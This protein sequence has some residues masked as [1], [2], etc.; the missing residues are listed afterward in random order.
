MQSQD[1]S[2]KL[3]EIKESLSKH[4]LSLKERLFFKTLIMMLELLLARS[5]RNSNS[6]S[7]P[8]SQSHNRKKKSLS[9]NKRKLSDQN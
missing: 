7:V 1:I 2:R 8:V 4:K 3:S 9:K 5:E 6:G